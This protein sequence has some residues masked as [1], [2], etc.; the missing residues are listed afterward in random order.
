[1]EDNIFQTVIGDFISTR[2]NNVIE[3][4]LEKEDFRKLSDK[5][6]ETQMSIKDKLPLED[7]ELLFELDELTSQIKSIIETQTYLQGFKDCK[8][9]LSI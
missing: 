3:E 7:K 6:K 2:Q 4:L 1:M 5:Y 8:K 9:I